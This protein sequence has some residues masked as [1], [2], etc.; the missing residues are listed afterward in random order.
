MNIQAIIHIS[1]VYLTNHFIPCGKKAWKPGGAQK[2]STA[3]L[4]GRRCLYSLKS[5]SGTWAANPCLCS[6]TN[7]ES[8]EG[9]PETVFHSIGL[10]WSRKYKQAIEELPKRQCEEKARLQNPS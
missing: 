6:T 3:E 1:N 9:I 2:E 4:F 8:K 5:A 10:L 7:N